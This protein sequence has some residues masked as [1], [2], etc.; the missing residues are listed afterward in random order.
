MKAKERHQLKENEFAA[1][2]ARV[3]AAVNQNRDRLVVV[4]LAVVV[5]AAIVGGYF[6]WQRRTEDR[7]GAMLG[8]AMAT[9]DAQIAPASTLPG[10][11][12]TPGTFPTEK[13]RDEAALKALQE[14][15]NSFPSAQAG[16]AAR[17]QAAGTLLRLN[18]LT[19]AEQTFREVADRA[20]SSV[21][22]PVARLGVAETLLAQGKNDEA[23]KAFSDLAADRDGML[24]VDGVL[25]QLARA[26]SK[27]GKPQ[28]ARAAFKRVV[29]E[30]PESSYVAEARRELALLGT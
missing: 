3:V 25:M 6:F 23:I 9:V 29:D 26:C 21:Y 15:A 12:Q 14:V 20:G 5:V 19:E 1:S 11:A 22:G 8:I 10:A 4:A 7:A 24:P 17:Y 30:F 13:A 27:A 2:T 16:I 18:R 28:E